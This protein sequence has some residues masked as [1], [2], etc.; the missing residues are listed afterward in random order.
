MAGITKLTYQDGVVVGNIE[1]KARLRNPIS[2][3]LVRRFDAALFALLEIAK[4][5]SL[6]EIGCAEG[7]VTKALAR[8]HRVPIRAS[9]LSVD[10]IGR[11]QRERIPNV[12]F[13]QRSIYDL[14]P[15]E[16]H[17]D[18]VVCCEVIEHLESPA[19]AL[20]ILRDLKA[21][22]YLF[23]V[24]REPIWRLMNMARGRYLS[25]YGNTPG[26][27]NHWSSRAFLRFLSRNGFTPTSVRHPLP[28][29]MALG[30]FSRNLSD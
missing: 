16:D 27:V 9:D 23:S 11:L 22:H 21:N 25:N 14:E 3:Q 6:N 29:T 4:P 2:R 12:E 7:R 18:V 8:K 19:K 5:R 28:W 1:D 24:P 13:L 10:L 26:H 17:A 30:T 20:A 15:G